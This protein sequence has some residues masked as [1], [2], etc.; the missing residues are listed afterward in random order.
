MSII[1]KW[2]LQAVALFLFAWMATVA[3]NW[4]STIVSG[5]GNDRLAQLNEGV[6]V[7]GT[8]GKHSVAQEA[9]FASQGE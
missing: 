5:T 9:V 3:A 8:S 7:S 6:L 1:A 2:A 4:S